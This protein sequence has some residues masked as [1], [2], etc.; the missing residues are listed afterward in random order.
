MRLLGVGVGRAAAT[1]FSFA[2][3]AGGCTQTIPGALLCP[4]PPNLCTCQDG[5]DQG[6]VVVR[7]RMSDSVAGALLS[8]GECCCVPD[9][10]PMTGLVHQ[11]CP[12]PDSQCSQS[13]AWLVRNV[14][15]HITSVDTG[16]TCIIIANC[17]DAELATP[18]CLTPGVYDL[19]L[20][21]DVEDYDPSCGQFVCAH[22]PALSPPTIRRT[23]VANQAVNLDGLVLG[24]N[25]PPVSL[26]SDGGTSGGLCSMPMDGGSHD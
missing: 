21:A 15:L 18:Y 24:V 25:A 6:S 26:P 5:S 10:V 9:T 2:L 8:R 20:T 11:Q 13:P 3:G 22:R 23:V 4:D 1:V 16:A 19:Q 17:T 7:W 12:S 14:Q